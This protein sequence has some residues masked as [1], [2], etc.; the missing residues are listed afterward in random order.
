MT[1]WREFSDEAPQLAAQ[2]ERRFAAHQH[3][4][5][6]TLRSDGSPRLCGTEV[7]LLD[8]ELWLG[9]MTGNLRFADLRRDPR[10]AIHSGS[11]EPAQWSGDARVAG[12]AVEVTDPAE[13]ERYRAGVPGDVPPG[14]FELFRVALTEAVTVG[15]DDAREHLVVESWRPGAAVRRTVRR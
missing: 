2:V 3:K 7:E 4:V 15:L 1:T 9:G 8:G 14:P 12:L 6:A 11:D 10:V 5:M 13:H